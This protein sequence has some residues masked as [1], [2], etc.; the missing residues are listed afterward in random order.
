[1]ISVQITALTYMY[2]VQC[3]VLIT[4]VF[5]SFV[6]HVFVFYLFIEINAH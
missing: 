2:I 5:I 1:M 3:P 4:H 6:L